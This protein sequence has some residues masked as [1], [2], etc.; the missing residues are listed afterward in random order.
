MAQN[1]YEG[2]LEFIV[3]AITMPTDAD[4]STSFSREHFLVVMCD[5]PRHND[6]ILEFPIRILKPS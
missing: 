6:L 1:T 5:I 4:F 2:N 3:P